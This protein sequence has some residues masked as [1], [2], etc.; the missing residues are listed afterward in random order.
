MQKENLK[1]VWQFYNSTSRDYTYYSQVHK[2]FSRIDMMWASQKILLRTTTTTKNR[3]F[4]KD[5]VGP[6]SDT[7]TGNDQ[8]IS[9]QLETKRGPIV[10]RREYRI[11]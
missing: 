4:S 8:E 5:K 3:D 11:D 10:A 7:L 2:R 9:L 6:Q 1:D